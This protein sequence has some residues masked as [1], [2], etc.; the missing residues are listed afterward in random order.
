MRGVRTFI[1][2]S[3]RQ[4]G[5]GEI[6]SIETLIIIIIIILFS[7][8]DVCSTQSFHRNVNGSNELSHI[9]FE[10]PFSYLLQLQRHYH[11]PHPML[12]PSR[13][14]PLLHLLA[15]NIHWRPRYQLC[16]SRRSSKSCMNR[17]S[18]RDVPRCSHV[19][20]KT[21]ICGSRSHNQFDT[22][23]SSFIQAHIITHD[24]FLV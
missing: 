6:I 18:F 5:K 12:F 8:H 7:F 19:P 20:R 16:A 13:L 23:Y 21:Q 2:L 9:L 22:V 3:R 1:Y 15:R 11:L 10:L 17:A 4:I 14:N 24:I